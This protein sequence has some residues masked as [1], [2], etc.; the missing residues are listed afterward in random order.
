MPAQIGAATGSAPVW[1]PDGGTIAYV[2]GANI[3]IVT[4][5]AGV[6]ST[7]VAGSDPSWSPDG[8]HI[9]YTSAGT[10]VT[11]A[12]ASCVS[13]T[14]IASGSQPAWSPDGTTIAYQ[15]GGVISVTA[16]TG[17]GSPTTVASGT[18]PNWSPDGDSIVYV[19]AGG[20]IAVATGPPWSTTP[21]TS[22]TAD[23]APDWQNAKP[24]AS[25]AP[26]IFGSAQT[27]QLL[28]ASNGFWTGAVSFA[29]QWSRCNSS[30]GSCSNIAGAT[31]SSY[32]VVSADVNNTLRVVVTASNA[33]GSTASS[34]S[35]ATA[36]VTAAG[37]VNPPLNTAYP[38]VSLGTGQTAP[39]VGSSVSTTAGSW[40]GSFP[41][42]FTYQWKWCD[43]AQSSC[44][45]IVGATSSFYT[46][47]STYFGKVLRV[48]VTATNSAASVSQNS[49]ATPAVAEIAPKLRVTPQIISPRPNPVVDQVLSLTAGTWDGA[50]APTIAYSWR[51]CN[52]P[53]D[54]ASCVAIADATATTYTP[55]VADIG[56][57]LR[58]WITGTNDAG[59]DFGITNHTF[60]IVDKQHFSPT[61][62]DL[63]TI[64]GTFTVGRKL[65]ASAGAF[66]GDA[67]IATSLVW[68]R[69]DPTGIQC[70]RIPGATK[71]SYSTTSAD[72]GSTL[73][74]AVTAKNFYGTIVALSDPSNPVL[75]MP[76]HCRGKQLRAGSGND[77]IAGTRCDDVIRS[78][79]GNDTING[80]GGYDTI[81]G[82]AGHK[83]ITV[84]GPGSSRIFTRA[85][86]DTIYAANGF[87]DTI[88]CGSGRNKV[89]ADSFD[90][91]KHCT[92]V[93]VQTPGSSPGAR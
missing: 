12:V 64:T 66:S 36:I 52:A 77:F 63:P 47:P 14:T 19:T 60:T 41:M 13:T 25:V 31:S 20:A 53:G 49:E 28:S 82:G 81:Y 3:H 70:L 71:T 73:R 18:S 88:V 92:V 62:T 22:G 90:V 9:A 55:A 57:T 43:S 89:F 50:P 59:S 4:Y 10:V 42:T 78:G 32:A 29:Y 2:N 39:L 91:V 87:E 35:S 27:G 80:E 48:M 5:P 26:S 33:A 61:A 83:V 37:V 45:D 54:I 16:A 7:L 40:S 68:R 8:T 85:G 11:C 1:S 86:S 15:S 67:P 65:V 46:V 23:T 44:F 51:R 75:G 24:I 30:G 79:G 56:S 76:A 17:S 93:V 74:V 21:R 72:I 38:V 34:P 58:V 6:D 84:P 69:C